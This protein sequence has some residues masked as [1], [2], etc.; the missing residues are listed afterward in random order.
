MDVAAV[1]EGSRARVASATFTVALTG[2][3]E[4]LEATLTVKR[5]DTNAV[6][7]KNSLS[8]PA[9][10]DNT[11]DVDANSQL[12][13]VPPPGLPAPHSYALILP[14]LRPTELP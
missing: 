11:L 12:K 7:K 4:V 9:K 3:V 6:Q 2:R 14:R 1:E 10:L 13:V 5:T 8:Y